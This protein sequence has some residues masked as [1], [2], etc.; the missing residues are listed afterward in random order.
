MMAPPQPPHTAQPLR[1]AE[2]AKGRA[3]A[4]P[5]ILGPRV[6]SL[7]PASDLSAVADC[8]MGSASKWLEHRLESLVDLGSG[9]S[10]TTYSVC[11]FRKIPSV[12]GGSVSLSVKWGLLSAQLSSLPPGI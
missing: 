3:P 6:L 1:E 12:L 2:G 11:D 8:R 9:P 4:L 5:V 7:S 10:S